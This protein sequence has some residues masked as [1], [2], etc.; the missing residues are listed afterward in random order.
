MQCTKYYPTTTDDNIAL[1]CPIYG[2]RDW[3]RNLENNKFQ[4]KLKIS[5]GKWN[6]CTIKY[7]TLSKYTK[8]GLKDWMTANDNGLVELL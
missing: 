2:Q 3:V 6:I 8:E 7:K 1:I 4:N 5:C